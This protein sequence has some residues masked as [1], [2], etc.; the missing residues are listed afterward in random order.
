MSNDRNAQ[1]TEQTYSWTWH[2][3][4]ALVAAAALSAIFLPHGAGSAEAAAAQPLVA[5]ETSAATLM[6]VPSPQPGEG[7][8]ALVL[9]D[10]PQSY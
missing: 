1:D 10:L 6:L 3:M 4:P 5:V 8:P 2:V 7:E 9:S